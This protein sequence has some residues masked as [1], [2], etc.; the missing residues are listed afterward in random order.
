MPKNEICF[1]FKDQLAIYHNLYDK[2]ANEWLGPEIT[3]KLDLAKN[4]L[5]RRKTWVLPDDFNHEIYITNQRLI[6]NN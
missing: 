5:S 3:F 6:I 4:Y 2:K 1:Y